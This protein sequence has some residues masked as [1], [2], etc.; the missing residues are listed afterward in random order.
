[1]DE[2]M[3]EGHRN[4]M[5]DLARRFFAAITA[6]EIDAVREM[7]APDAVIW[8]NNDGVEQGVEQ[9]LAVL[10]WVTKN[11]AGFRYEDARCQAT[12][13]GFVEQHV[14]RGRA[15]NG[16]ELAMPACIVCTVVDGR[17]TR[18]DEYLDSAH[19]APLLAEP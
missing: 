17:I 16:A 3:T 4:S 9:N 12:A 19:L 2:R 6:G 5:L 8:H 14:T 18:V 10:S 11:I 1:M 13:D 7:Y 15:R